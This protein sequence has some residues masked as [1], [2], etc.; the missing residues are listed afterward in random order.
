MWGGKDEE[1]ESQFYSCLYAEFIEKNLLSV[2]IVASFSTN[3][4]SGFLK[5]NCFVAF[6]AS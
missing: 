3:C 2:Y 6:T 5:S 4:G 1:G